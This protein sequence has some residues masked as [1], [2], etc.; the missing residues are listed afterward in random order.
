MTQVDYGFNAVESILLNQADLEATMSGIAALKATRVRIL[1][2]W[3]QI[4]TSR[5]NYSWTAL[6]AVMACAAKY[7]LK[8]LVLLTPFGGW[9][10]MPTW[11]PTP[12][13]FG[14]FCAAVA[15]R[16]GVTQS[17]STEYE[18]WNEPNNL[19]NLNP[20]TAAFYTEW[21]KNGYTAIKSVQPSALVLTGGL[22]ANATNIY[23]PFAGSTID[24]FDFL[25]GIYAAG[26]QNYFDAVA[27]HPY[28]LDNQFNYI[29]PTLTAPFIADDLLIRSYM[30][31]Q[32]DSAKPLWWTEIGF[33]TA[34]MSQA[35]QTMWL[36]EHFGIWQSLAN[37][38]PVFFYSYRD[39]TNNANDPLNTLGV[40][41]YSFQP[42]QSYAWCKTI[43]KAIVAAFG[44]SGSLAAVQNRRSGM[45]GA[46]V[47]TAT[48]STIQYA[49]AA[50][51]GSG[52][53]EV[54][55]FGRPAA[56]LGGEGSLNA[57]LT[58]SYSVA[59]A[60]S[61]SGSA[62]LGAAKITALTAAFSGGGALS[63]TTMQERLYSYTFTGTGSTK[64]TSLFTEFG[65]GYRVAGGIANNPSTS[66][67]GTY[68]SGAI[69]NYDQ[70]SA[71]H[72]ASVTLAPGSTTAGSGD[73]SAMAIV[74]ADASGNNW[75]GCTGH[76]GWANSIQIIT[77]IAGVIT[78]QATGTTQL[79]EDNDVMTLV[80]QGN[81]YTVYKNGVSTGT[82]WNDLSGVFPGINN[83]RT[84]FGFQ[85]IYSGAL[86]STGGISSWAGSDLAP[87]V[88]APRATAAFSGSGQLAAAALIDLIAA[89]TGSGSLVAGAQATQQVSATFS[90]SGALSVF[91]GFY[92][93]AA[94][95]GSGAL[96]ATV[97]PVLGAALAGAGQLGATLTPML[98]AAFAGSGALSATDA[99]V[100]AAGF[101]GSGQ[102]AATFAQ[103]LIAANFTGGGVLSSAPTQLGPLYQ[104]SAQGTPT[105]GSVS[106]THNCPTSDASTWV[107]AIGATSASAI[108]SFSMT[109]GGT[110]MTLIGTQGGGSS[111]G[112]VIYALQNPPT[113]NQTVTFTVFASGGGTRVGSSVSFTNVGDVSG[114][115][116]ATNTGTTPAVTVPSESIYSLALGAMYGMNQTV[117]EPG[118]NYG[119]AT[120]G[121]PAVQGS[122]SNPLSGTIPSGKWLAAGIS[123]DPPVLAW[124]SLTGS[125]AMSATVQPAYSPALN[126]SGSLSVQI[127]IPA[128]FSGAGGLAGTISP[129]ESAALSG[130]GSLSAT[131]SVV[132]AANLSGSGSLSSTIGLGAK[133][134]GSGAL[135][136]TIT[137]GPVYDNVGSG[138]TTLIGNSASGSCTGTQVVGSGSNRLMLVW[139]AVNTSGGWINSFSSLTVTSSLGGTFT[140][141]SDVWM[142]LSGQ[143]TQS[144][145][146]FVC[147]APAVGTHTLTASVNTGSPWIGGN[148]TIASVSYVGVNGYQNLATQGGGSNANAALNLAITSAVGHVPVV[149][150]ADGNSG[151]G[152]TFNKTLRA[153]IASG[154]SYQQY[155]QIGD[156]AGASTVTFTTTTN[157]TMVG[158]IGVDLY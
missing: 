145:H 36:Q 93:N 51:T 149:G 153:N 1:A 122:T 123:L 137:A 116:S 29:E 84:G 133:L 115:T 65:L 27:N 128:T 13:D 41:D 108:T 97:V 107:I 90:G 35:Q 135:S 127:A 44:G 102:I 78:V 9:F 20:P 92:A 147:T 19:G 6:D 132:G 105:A 34:S 50:F 17:I 46:G 154:S 23:W 33:P 152:T 58:Q 88:V 118:T 117:T 15:Q 81:T 139:V 28:A 39:T 72:S 112:L 82:T 21:L 4:A 142:A 151:Y 43:N 134:A 148:I 136:A 91:T 68:Y 60:F 71:D 38:G 98:A 110:A 121:I 150:M 144:I 40:V 53:L 8:P 113:G 31:S 103:A 22:E 125:G 155:V 59:A 101:N 111:G 140:N 106:W 96:A 126:G 61:G 146:L 18:I 30:D 73:R 70:L 47:F 138:G 83:T 143:S 3:T 80:A 114:F 130:S 7:K 141:I 48:V 54:D 24:P 2:G 69:Y 37:R 74:R 94:F 12:G 158:A 156:A 5:G 131:A 63:A 52:A 57:N 76:W 87:T 89:F 129:N 95:A 100:L 119:Q 99:A 109:Y 67:N 32:G 10:M 79:D 55:V 64:P 16:Y 66:T 25:K 45:S 124:P 62:V 14:D 85:F 26:G 42:K 75:V 120:L 157:S 77:C 49:T 11:G 56:Q 86:Y 104:A